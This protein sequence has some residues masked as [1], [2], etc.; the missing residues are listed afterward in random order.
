MSRLLRLLV[1]CIL[2]IVV[3]AVLAPVW[4]GGG[5]PA[6]KDTVLTNIP[7]AEYHWKALRGQES[8]FWCH[9][10][11]CGFPVHAESQG[12]F[13][14]P[15]NVI[16]A[17][18]LPAHLVYPFRWIFSLVVAGLAMYA[19]LR[20]KAISVWAAFVG[21]IGYALG[22][23]WIARLDMLPL[24]LAAPVLPLGWLA[25]EWMVNRRW[26]RG[27]ALGACAIG[28]GLLAGHFQLTVIAMTGIVL[29]AFGRGTASGVLASTVVGLTLM[30]CVGMGLAGVQVMPTLELL[31]RSSR[32]SSDLDASD[33]SLFPLQLAGM[34]FPRLFG[35]Q[36]TVTFDSGQEWTPGSYWGG[37]VFWEACPYVGAAIVLLAIVA[38]ARRC[39]GTVW[40]VIIALAGALLAIGKYTPAWSGVQHL[41]ILSGFRIPSR[42]FLLSAASVAALAG[43]GSDAVRTLRKPRIWGVG[44]VLVAMLLAAGL[45]LAVTRIPNAERTAAWLGMTGERLHQTLTYAPQTLVPWK[46][47]QAVPLLV[48][49]LLGIAVLAQFP[50]SMIAVLVFLELGFFALRSLPPSIQLDKLPQKALSSVSLPFGRVYSDPLYQSGGEWDRLKA[51]PANTNWLSGSARPDVRGS[52][53]DLRQ[54]LY[55]Q[56]MKEEFQSGGHRLLSLAGVNAIITRRP[57][58]EAGLELIRGGEVLTYHVQNAQ[59][60]AHFPEQVRDLQ[61]GEDGLSA[62]LNADFQPGGDVLLEGREQTDVETGAHARTE[63]DV[64]IR[65]WGQGHIEIETNGEGGILRIAESHDP[66]WHAEID[67][68]SEKIYRADY[69]F[70]ALQVPPGSHHVTLQYS[71]PRFWLGAVLSIASLLLAIGFW[72]ASFGRKDQP[73]DLRE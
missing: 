25:V 39:P 63:A 58:S 68:Q 19:F 3:L 21:G 71:P 36:R 47:D 26:N 2:V 46:T 22:G 41:P 37:G 70:M 8:L 15:L 69:R 18:S 38:V 44:I 1:P 27:V 57:L 67:G 10:G 17:A 35:F 30:L 73:A 6:T 62:L 11:G 20:G 49:L 34:I 12:G 53:F 33:Y 40:L 7:L 61:P 42:F 60:L 28:W 32:L 31:G 24:L 56:A 48:M 55:S 14:H 51:L 43:M 66:G 50:R 5:F 9:Y 16:T 64:R 72:I 45:L 59:P 29:Y 54:A 23:F 65:H 13:F 4:W 52:L